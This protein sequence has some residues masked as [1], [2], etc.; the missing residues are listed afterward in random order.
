MT[1]CLNRGLLTPSY[2]KATVT[3]QIP[4]AKVVFI[5]KT[6]E[7]LDLSLSLDF[8]ADSAIKSNTVFKDGS[9]SPNLV[10]IEN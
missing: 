9:A 7:F 2:P 3:K 8:L 6:A 10:R 4:L 1:S 5:S